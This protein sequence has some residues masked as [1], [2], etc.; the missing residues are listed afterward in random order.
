[1]HYRSLLTDYTTLFKRFVVGGT[2]DA[3][4]EFTHR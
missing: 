4:Q 1:M 2:T 3:L